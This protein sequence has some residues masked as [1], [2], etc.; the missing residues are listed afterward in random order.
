MI[1]ST[2]YQITNKLPN[3]RIVALLL[4]LADKRLE[5]EGGGANLTSAIWPIS[6]FSKIRYVEPLVGESYEQS[7]YFERSGK[8][9]LATAGDYLRGFYS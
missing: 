3:R 9:A 7:D 4:V 8:R 1:E 6:D 2:N 5:I